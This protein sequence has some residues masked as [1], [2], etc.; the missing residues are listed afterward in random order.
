[1][2]TAII[3]KASFISL[4]IETFFYGLYMVLFVICM[5][6]LVYRKDKNAPLN[7]PMIL[8]TMALFSMSTVHVVVDFVRGLRAFFSAPS[9]LAYYAEIWD[10]LS[11]FKQ[12]LYA[13]NNIVADGLVVYRCY[14]VWG[15]SLYVIVVPVLMLIATTVC[16]YLAVYN[17]SQVHPGDNVFASNIAEW[18]T[19]LFSL[20]LATNIIVTTLIATRIWWLARQASTT[21]GHRHARKYHNAVAIIIES[22]SIYSACAMTLLILYVH[23]TNAQYLVYDSL[24]Q[25]MVRTPL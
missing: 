14:V 25:I 11:I 17:F 4:C 13:T 6:I 10:G 20:S 8:A 7:W 1:M 23:R 9:A 19:A 15:R 24:A 2:L 21:L 5:Y 22:G 16:G 18:G 12:A 3:S